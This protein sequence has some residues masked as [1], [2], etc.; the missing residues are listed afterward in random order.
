MNFWEKSFFLKFYRKKERA[1]I[2][3]E[4][5][6]ERSL[7]SSTYPQ[8]R[9]QFGVIWQQQQPFSIHQKFLKRIVEI[10]KKRKDKTIGALEQNACHGPA[11]ALRSGRR[12]KLHWDQ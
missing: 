10:K 3:I 2:Q 4:K 9:F 6:R 11:H 1:L 7:P 12:L 8:I 5:E